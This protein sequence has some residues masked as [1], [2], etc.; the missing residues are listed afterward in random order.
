[1]SFWFKM[2]RMISLTT[3][4]ANDG[5]DN[6]IGQKEKKNRSGREGGRRQR[7]LSANCKA[8]VDPDG[9]SSS[10]RSDRRDIHATSRRHVGR[11][12]KDGAAAAAGRCCSVVED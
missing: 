6:R 10:T 5:G 4:G 3:S 8:E 1:M 11:K 2:C 9:G 7:P 12:R